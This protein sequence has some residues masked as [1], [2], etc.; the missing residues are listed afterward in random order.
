MSTPA[1]V[2]QPSRGRSPGEMKQ[3]ATSVLLQ[4]RSTMNEN[5]Y[6]IP[7]QTLRWPNPSTELDLCIQWDLDFCIDAEDVLERASARSEE[8]ACRTVAV[9][10]AQPNP[11]RSG[12]G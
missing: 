4:T 1:R 12:Q 9:L 5:P 11:R 3:E 10:G 2:L 7:P 6:Q 8:I